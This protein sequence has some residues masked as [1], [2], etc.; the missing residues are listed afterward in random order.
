MAELSGRVVLVVGAQRGIGYACASAFAAAGATVAAAD[1]PGS[2][3]EEARV[4]S[5]AASAHTVDVADPASVER[6]VAEVVASHDR[7]DVLVNAAGVLF[8][9]PFLDLRPEHWTR[10]LAVNAGGT[11][12]LAQQAARQFIRQG[13]G[14]RIIAF[15]SIVSRTARLHNVAY[16]ASKAAVVQAVRCMALELAAHGI[17]VNAISPGSTATEMLIDIQA[18]G[19]PAV[20]ESVIRGD[21]AS[22]RLGIPLGRLADPADQAAVAVF[23]AGPG[24][25][26]ITG[27]EINVDGG[28]SVV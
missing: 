27:Q 12:L 1:L 2:A 28:Q 8:V 16:A 26:H 6:L 19:D 17:T 24:A 11:V 7:L 15:A 21:A 13:G 25:A 23:L 9:E 20:L 14:G 18:G 10:T 22:W 3:I 5:S 4:R